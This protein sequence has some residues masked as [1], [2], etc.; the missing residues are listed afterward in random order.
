MEREYCLIPD[1]LI[2]SNFQYRFLLAQ[3]HF[4]SLT[5]QATKGGVEQILQ[6][7][8]RDM[9]K[10]YNQAMER[11]ESQGGEIE[12]LVKRALCWIVYAMR[13]LT[14][15]EI[16]HALAAWPGKM[17]LEKDF[18]PNLE[19][20]GSGSAGLI[21]FDHKSGIVALAHKTTESY[22]RRT[23]DRWFPTPQTDIAKCCITYLSFDVF[24]YGICHTPMEFEARL[25][26]YALYDYAA[27]H[28]GLHA[29]A[30]YRREDGLTTY[31]PA[32]LECVNKVSACSQAMLAYKDE[33]TENWHVRRTMTA[34]HLAAY[35]G[36]FNTIIALLSKG[37]PPDSKDSEE[38][39]P[40]IVAEQNNQVKVVELLLET[41][42]VDLDQK[43]AWGRTP[44]LWAAKHKFETIA[45]MLVEKLGVC[46][47]AKDNI[48]RT[49]LLWAVRNN[50][51][52]LVSQLLAKGADQNAKDNNG[53]TTMHWAALLGYTDIVGQ[54]LKERADPNC[55]GNE[56]YT[57]MSCAATAGNEAVV[58]LLLENGSANES[59]ADV[60]DWCRTP[61][62]HA[63]TAGNAAVV[64]LLLKNDSAKRTIASLD[65]WRRTPLSHAAQAGHEAVVSLLL[66]DGLLE[67]EA[68]N[69]KDIYDRTALFW[70]AEN[71]HS[72]VVSSLLKRGVVDIG[73]RDKWGMTALLL[74]ERSGHTAVVGLLRGR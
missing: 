10:T 6:N 74:A 68:V 14:P 37:Y 25:Q 60:D 41:D 30:S 57:P 24:K 18:I 49:P 44:L 61:L 53:W 12:K 43:D 62:S 64:K 20:L 46:L 22:L 54:L 40:L 8:S 52:Q 58:R 73:A 31:L 67:D 63:A 29:Y 2:I 3:L 45:E 9:E 69:I 32:F 71:G 34:V 23:K 11:I 27:Q 26:E 16:Q 21:I 7:L 33:S 19:V 56:G 1:L 38:Q 15:V 36:L 70:A 48:G 47:D 17:S 35:F 39:T 5:S 59:I 66:E 50:S 42:G 55:K 28:W 13:R 65:K 72:N 51:E 4:D